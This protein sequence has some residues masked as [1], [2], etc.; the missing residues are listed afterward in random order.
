MAQ[1][2]HSRP[3]QRPGSHC[4]ASAGRAAPGNTPL[5]RMRRPLSAA[6]LPRTKESHGSC[7]GRASFKDRLRTCSAGAHPH[8][9]P[10]EEVP[11]KGCCYG[12]LVFKESA[13][14]QGHQTE[15]LG[16]TPGPPPL[17]CINP[18]CV[19]KWHTGRYGRLPQF[20][21]KSAQVG[22]WCSCILVFH[23]ISAQSH[24]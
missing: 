11:R 5:R 1:V 16:P 20:P 3:P 15:M 19:S 6:W 22:E 13:L 8:S 10:D 2:C 24:L 21:T 17:L 4:A 7:T 14:G 12:W 18:C 9:T 23:P